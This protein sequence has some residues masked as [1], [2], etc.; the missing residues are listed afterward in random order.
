MIEWWV[1]ELNDNWQPHR[2]LTMGLH[3]YREAMAEARKMA[4]GNHIAHLMIIKVT[5]KITFEATFQQ[6]VKM[7]PKALEDMVQCPTT[8]EK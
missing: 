8:T 2:F 3:S 6:V 7:V 4:D 1:L 5:S